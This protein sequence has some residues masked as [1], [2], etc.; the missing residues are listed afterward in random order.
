[1]RC[2]KRETPVLCQGLGFIRCGSGVHGSAPATVF[3]GA[4]CRRGL[5]TVAT[6]RDA[7]FFLL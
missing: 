5:F 1:M 6:T 4:A 7:N 2:V 3:L